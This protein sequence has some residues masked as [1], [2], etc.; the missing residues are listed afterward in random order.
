MDLN[1]RWE[2]NAFLSAYIQSTREPKTFRWCSELLPLQVVNS[3]FLVRTCYLFK[4]M[5]DIKS[6]SFKLFLEWLHKHRNKNKEKKERE[7]KRREERK[8]EKWAQAE[9]YEVREIINKD[10]KK[11]N[12]TISLRKPRILM[13]NHCI[14]LTTLLIKIIKWNVSWV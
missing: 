14:R 10:H 4:N 2:A 1:T 8:K 3:F 13:G 5:L 6:I 11:M 12:L 7:N 9:A